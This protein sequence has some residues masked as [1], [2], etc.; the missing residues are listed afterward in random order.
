MAR[1]ADSVVDLHPTNLSGFSESYAVG[2]D[3]THQVGMAGGTASFFGGSNTH[4]VL[5]G[6]TPD[7]A[8][9]LHPT[10]LSGFD[11]SKAVFISGTEQV[12]SG[13]GT[14]TGGNEHALLWFGTADSAVDLNPTLLADIDSSSAR[15]TNGVVQVGYGH[16]SATDSPTALLWSG[17]A[18]SAIDLGSLLPAGFFYSD[19]YSVDANGNVWGIAIDADRVVHAIEWTPVPEPTT[20]V[21]LM[22]ILVS[23]CALRAVH[24]FS[25]L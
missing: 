10:K 2:T 11:T 19:A 25:Q 1:Y 3:G 15:G 22:S 13:S 14:G 23:V 7:S 17:A 20:L 5:W 16:N 18:N 9:D 21:L 12:G 4:A 6:G 8:V 24:H